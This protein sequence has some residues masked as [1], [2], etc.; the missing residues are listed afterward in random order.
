MEQPLI[1]YL[2]ERYAKSRATQE[3]AKRIFDLTERE[4]LALWEAKPLFVTKL[5]AK[6]NKSKDSADSYMRSELGPCL[7]WVTKQAR[8]DGVM[9]R[10]TAEVI[11]HRDSEKRFRMQPGERHREESK[12]KISRSK[13]GVKHTEARKAKVSAALTGV[14]KSAESNSKRSASMK[15]YWA[16]KRDDE[17]ARKT[18][19]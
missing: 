1:D 16:K 13:K 5:A 2:N 8:K 7:S 4:H 14:A 18:G 15:A 19:I 12:Q 6:L 17:A 10:D 11:S 9:N 3:Q